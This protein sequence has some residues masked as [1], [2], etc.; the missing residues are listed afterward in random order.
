MGYRLRIL[1]QFAVL[2]ETMV[3]GT[4]R[5]PRTIVVE[6][7]VISDVI[8]KVLYGLAGPSLDQGN[9]ATFD[10]E[11]APKGGKATPKVAILVA[12]QLVKRI[13]S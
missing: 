9:D 2:T 3:T 1:S 6:K 12:H 4:L 10:Y 7:A 8:T 11:R 13:V 5:L